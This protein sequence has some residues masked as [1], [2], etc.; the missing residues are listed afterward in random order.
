MLFLC[1]QDALQCNFW[2]NVETLGEH[3]GRTFLWRG[4]KISFGTLWAPFWSYLGSIGGVISDVFPKYFEF[5]LF[6]VVFS[7]SVL[8]E[9]L[10]GR[11]GT[12]SGSNVGFVLIV[13]GIFSF[14][15]I[16]KSRGGTGN[17][18]LLMP[19]FK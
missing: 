14:I 2:K 9:C 5:V 12:T 17:I 13:L 10:R 7:V 1:S 4:S 8:V 18:N 16:E 6:V 19:H 3:L 15:I 11:F